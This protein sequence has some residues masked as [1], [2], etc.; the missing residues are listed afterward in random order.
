[1]IGKLSGTY[2]IMKRGLTLL[3]L[4]C[5]ALTLRAQKKSKLAPPQ[6]PVFVL[7]DSTLNGHKYVDLGLPSG[8]LWAT[9]NVGAKREKDYGRYYSWGELVDRTSVSPRN[10]KFGGYW[11]GSPLTKYNQ[12]ANMGQ[13]DNLEHLEPEDDAATQLW[14]AGWMMP[15]DEQ[16][17]E[18]LDDAYTTKVSVARGKGRGILFVS[19]INGRSIFLPAAGHVWAGTGKF[20]KYYGFYWTNT[21]GKDV[22][23]YEMR[24]RFVN[25][26][27]ACGVVTDSR[28]CANTIRACCKKF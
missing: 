7:S 14:G 6:Q 26:V 8:T 21:C 3:V 23:A 4:L 28:Y 13:V 17:A 19:K 9:T 16:F 24:I 12:D 2:N 18:L 10:Y 22:E 5:A 25:K 1:M 27:A 11:T 20:E 15:T